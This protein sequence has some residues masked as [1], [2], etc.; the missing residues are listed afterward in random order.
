MIGPNQLIKSIDKFSESVTSYL[1]PIVRYVGHKD[2]YFDVLFRKF[3]DLQHEKRFSGKPSHLVVFDEFPT[4]VLEEDKNLPAEAG[5]IL[6]LDE[7]PALSDE[8]L[9]ILKNRISVTLIKPTTDELYWHCRAIL[10]LQDVS[11]TNHKQYYPPLISVDLEFRKSLGD[12]IFC[13]IQQKSCLITTDSEQLSDALINFMLSSLPEIL[14]PF[15][16]SLNNLESES[17]PL[18][19]LLFLRTECD[20]KKELDS[21]VSAYEACQDNR[22]KN[23]IAF[24]TI[25]RSLIRHTKS[26]SSYTHFSNL[27]KRTIDALLIAYWASSF[28][29]SNYLI[30]R[31]YSRAQINRTLKSSGFDAVLYLSELLSQEPL[32]T[33]PNNWLREIVA[34]YERPTIDDILNDAEQKVMLGLHLRAKILDAASNAAGIPS[35][36]FRKRMKRLEKKESLLGLISSTSNDH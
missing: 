34:K 9:F 22:N 32:L 17:L 30:P 23:I 1:S 35:V 10:I 4:S 25:K 19:K 21:L 12:L 20:T 18:N 24:V 33:S 7:E 8:Q 14:E 5:Y 28:K 15:E 31:Y 36:T 13:S 27:K 11:Y 29:S 3:P 2:E 16:V 26:V 6:C